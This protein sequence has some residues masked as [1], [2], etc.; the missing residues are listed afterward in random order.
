M[1]TPCQEQHRGRPRHR[2]RP[3]PRSRRQLRASR[4]PTWSSVSSGR[5]FTKRRASGSCCPG[6]SRRGTWRGGRIRRAR[7]CRRCGSQRTVWTGARRPSPRRSLHVPG[8]RSGR[9]HPSDP[10]GPP[11]V[12]QSCLA[13]SLSAAAL[14]ATRSGSSPGDPAMDASG[15]DRVTSAAR[16]S[17]DG[18]FGCGLSPVA[19]RRRSR[20]RAGGSPSGRPRA[21]TT[22]S[23]G[24]CW[25]TARNRIS[26]SPPSRTTAGSSCCSTRISCS[27]RTAS[28]P[29]SHGPRER[30]S[31]SCRPTWARLRGP[32]PPRLTRSPCAP[33]PGAPP[34]SRTGTERPSRCLPSARS[35]G[36]RRGSSPWVEIPAATPGARARRQGGRR[37]SAPWMAAH[38]S[39]CSRLSALGPS[40]RDRWH[41]RHVRGWW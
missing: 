40:G 7:T 10:D 13:L 30:S 4:P 21:A 14:P 34:T 28:R 24:W 17:M 16:T 3:R 38:G 41:D 32:S 31:R 27:W 5:K 23:S 18:P 6:G 22:G 26:V 36:P 20:S 2:T 35:A 15:C 33:T 1:P 9:R 25:L 12:E 29:R 11:V 19:G 8:G 39:R 37:T